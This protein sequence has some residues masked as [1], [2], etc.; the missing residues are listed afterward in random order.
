MNK[1]SLSTFSL[2][3]GYIFQHSL[4]FSVQLSSLSH[5]RLLVTPWTAACQASLSITTSQS[6]LK[7]MYI[8][9]VMPF[10][11][12]ILHHPRFTTQ[13]YKGFS[14]EIKNKRERGEGEIERDRMNVSLPKNQNLMTYST[15]RSVAVGDA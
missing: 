12:L 13:I 10:N 5:V 6:L 1:I 14:N 9:S 15:V 4:L 11:Y 8:E 7:L 2:Y 3:Q